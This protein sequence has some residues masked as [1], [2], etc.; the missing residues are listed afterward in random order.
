MGVSLPNHFRFVSR[1]QAKPPSLPPA[2]S[3]VYLAD[4]A[5]PAC[6]TPTLLFNGWRFF[7]MAAAGTHARKKDP[8]LD[9][10]CPGASETRCFYFS[11]MYKPWSIDSGKCIRVSVYVNARSARKRGVET[12]RFLPLRN[13]S[14]SSLTE[15][16]LLRTGCRKCVHRQ[17]AQLWL[18]ELGVFKS[19]HV[20]GAVPLPGQ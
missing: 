8:C 9:H 11:C 7:P 16:V 20:H 19:T 15:V 10:S 5:F 3:G 14:N 18:V 2:F 1:R 4:A 17:R 12:P 13:A 6:P